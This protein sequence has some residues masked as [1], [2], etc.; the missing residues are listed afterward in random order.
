M[1]CSTSSPSPVPIAM[2]PGC[3]APA[4]I[5]PCEICPGVAIRDGICQLCEDALALIV[6]G[7]VAKV[8]EWT[9][10]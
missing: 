8:E 9:N 4:V 7:I 2:S 10:E 3:G 1:D 5:E 6:T